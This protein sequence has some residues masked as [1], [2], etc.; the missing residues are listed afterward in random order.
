MDHLPVFLDLK[1]KKIIVTGG[2]TV[3]ARRVERA[4]S[5]GAKVEVLADE[6]GSEFVE[7]SK[8]KNFTHTARGF[9]ESDLED[10]AVAYGAQDNPDDDQGLADAARAKNVLVN[11]ADVLENCDFITP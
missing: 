1:G 2:G 10:C 3:A 8:H 6:L 7:L 5:V 11:V 9:I 4:L